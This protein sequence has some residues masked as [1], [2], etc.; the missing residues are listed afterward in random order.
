MT[1]QR[2][3]FD[4]V[5]RS[6]SNGPDSRQT[7]IKKRYAIKINLA[8]PMSKVSVLDFDKVQSIRRGDYVVR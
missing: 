1:T 7:D 6:L 8:V 5:K 3:F 2:S 4:V